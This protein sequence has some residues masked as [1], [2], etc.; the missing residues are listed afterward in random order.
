MMYILS[1]VIWQTLNPAATH[2][3]VVS[4]LPLDACQS[5]ADKINM[6]RLF[7]HVVTG[8]ATCIEDPAAYH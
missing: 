7:P 1:I 5:L 3:V 8:S 2:T 4:G 6:P